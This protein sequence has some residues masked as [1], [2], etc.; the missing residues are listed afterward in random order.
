V[1]AGFAGDVNVDPEG[2][3]L[4]GCLLLGHVGVRFC[5]VWFDGRRRH[6]TMQI[7]KRQ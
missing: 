5:S 4:L 6:W 2:L 1:I 3:G 7:Q